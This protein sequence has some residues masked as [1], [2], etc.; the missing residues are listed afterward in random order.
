LDRQ[1]L[2]K[3]KELL[4]IWSSLLLY[5]ARDK[6]QSK[7]SVSALL[8]NL[9][10]LIEQPLVAFSSDYKLALVKNRLETLDRLNL[11]YFY[12]VEA[13]HFIQAQ[14]DNY[15]P[16]S[17]LYDFFK[18]L[19]N[20]RKSEY[21]SFSDTT[22]LK[23]ILFAFQ[24]ST[25]Q[26]QLLK[27]LSSYDLFQSILETLLLSRDSDDLKFSFHFL[28]TTSETI[29]DK[30]LRKTWTDL[31]GLLSTLDSYGRYLIEPQWEGAIGPLLQ[32]FAEQ[33]QPERRNLDLYWLFK[34][35]ATKGMRHE[36]P[37]VN[38]SVMKYILDHRLNL[39]VAAFSELIF[40]TLIPNLNNPKLYEY[41]E[42][43]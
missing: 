40:E 13:Y 2:G 35:L 20:E 8:E 30:S 10:Q 17:A 16:A 26:Q 23:I 22:I 29:P 15:P 32:H 27:L 9:K 42:A 19:L 24:H 5:F 1:S 7:D 28:K 36:N 6:E 11:L 14:T 34:I 38:R 43:Y 18:K 3:I 4:G 39:R 21:S 33:E 41:P 25:E 31:I 37:A 12:I